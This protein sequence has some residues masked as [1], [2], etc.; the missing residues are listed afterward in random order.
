MVSSLLSSA[1]RVSAPLARVKAPRQEA[2]T[3]ATVPAPP[4]DTVTLSDPSLEEAPVSVPHYDVLHPVESLKQHKPLIRQAGMAL[5]FVGIGASLGHLA[6]AWSY[7]P[8]ERVFQ[9]TVEELNA[10]RQRY[11]VQ[12]QYLQGM[13]TVVSRAKE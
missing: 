4:Q 6:T 7:E 8:R 13:Q 2:V 12:E 5:A 11:A 9:Q 1:S 3:P 10:L